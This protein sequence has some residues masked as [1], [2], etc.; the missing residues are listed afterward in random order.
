MIAYRR[1][2]GSVEAVQ[3]IDGRCNIVVVDITTHPN[4]NVPG[5]RVD[6]C[7]SGVGCDGIVVEDRNGLVL[8]GG[9]GGVGEDTNQSRSAIA[10]SRQGVRRAVTGDR[11][12]ERDST[13]GEATAVVDGVLDIFHCG[14]TRIRN[15]DVDRIGVGIVATGSCL[16]YAGRK[17]DDDGLGSVSFSPGGIATRRNEAK[18]GGGRTRAE[19][20]RASG[21]RLHMRQRDIGKGML[22]LIDDLSRNLILRVDVSRVIHATVDDTPTPLRMDRPKVLRDATVDRSIVGNQSIGMG[23]IDAALGGCVRVVG[24]RATVVHHGRGLE[25]AGV[26]DGGAKF[27]RHGVGAERSRGIDLHARGMR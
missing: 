18:G 6:R 13:G 9:A 2:N 22:T 3:I 7:D 19:G 23:I 25:G 20:H 26:D 24:E 17:M 4:G 16:R 5:R 21:I 1:S 10:T 14:R 12:S 8:S 11:S 15:E 27:I